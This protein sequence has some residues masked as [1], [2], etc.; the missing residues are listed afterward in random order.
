MT[1]EIHMEG[2]IQICAAA[3]A[4]EKKKKKCGV[5][6]RASL[7]GEELRNDG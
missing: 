6:G 3:L 4:K 2:P 7:C 5:G 1:S